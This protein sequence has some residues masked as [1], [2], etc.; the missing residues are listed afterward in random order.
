ML[1]LYLL[2]YRGPVQREDHP[3]HI[4]KDPLQLMAAAQLHTPCRP[5]AHPSSFPMSTKLLYSRVPSLT[6]GVLCKDDASL[7]AR[8]MHAGS[9]ASFKLAETR[10]TESRWVHWL[11]LLHP[12]RSFLPHP[13]SLIC[14]SYFLLLTRS[15]TFITRPLMLL[16]TTSIT[17]IALS[18][19]HPKNA[20]CPPLR[21]YRLAIP[22]LIW[23]SSFMN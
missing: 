20:V 10:S 9:C 5:S 7:E 2:Q 11:L 16:L 23:A 1:L 21:T 22:I 15:I 19:A 14:N 17:P 3:I 8:T 6:V 13:S 4:I 18:D 12:S